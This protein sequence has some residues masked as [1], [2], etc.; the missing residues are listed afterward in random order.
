[1]L[2]GETS[3]LPADLIKSLDSIDTLD[4]FAY[5]EGI[6][7]EG[8]SYTFNNILQMFKVNYDVEIRVHS[9]IIKIEEKAL[10]E[11]QFLNLINKDGFDQ[12]SLMKNN[13]FDPDF[14]FNSILGQI[15]LLS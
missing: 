4:C 9:I 7:T 5:K 1:M 6:D 10:D 15:N 3:S 13:L 14:D 11:S 2:D 12:S 8:L